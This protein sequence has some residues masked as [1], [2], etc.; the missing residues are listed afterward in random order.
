MVK[1]SSLPGSSVYTTYMQTYEKFIDKL[2]DF[3][4]DK[5]GKVVIIQPPNVPLSLWIILT[6]ISWLAADEYTFVIKLTAQLVLLLWSGFE[7]F[8]GA[9]PFR[10]VLGA[11]VLVYLFGSLLLRILSI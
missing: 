7:V 11:I 10:K 9:S 6:A 1:Y 2:P 4:R 3:F 8:N 5:D